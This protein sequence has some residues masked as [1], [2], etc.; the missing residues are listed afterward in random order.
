MDTES[1]PHY[2]QGIIT[3]DSADTAKEII[4]QIQQQF[5]QLFTKAQ[6]VVSPFAQG[7]PVYAPVMFRL[8]GPDEYNLRQLG[9]RYRTALAA[10]PGVTTTQATMTGGQAKLWLNI[11]EYEANNQGWN[12]RLIANRIQGQLDGVTAGSQLTG[13]EDTPVRVMLD[14]RQRQQP[15]EIIDTYFASS[16]NGGSSLLHLGSISTVEVSPA[17][18]N[19]FRRNGERTNVISAF[20]TPDALPPEVTQ[21][22]LENFQQNLPSLPPGYRLEIGGDS[23]ESEEASGNL[24]TFAPILTCMMIGAVILAFRSVS[25][26]MVIGAVAVLTIGFGLIALRVS[27]YPFGFNPLLGIAG[28]IGIAINDSIV[29]LAAIR[30]NAIAAA[31]DIAA[32]AE[33]AL[34]CSRHVIA[35]TLTT[36][37]GF[38]PLLLA[39][40]DFWP[41]LAVILAGGVAGATILATVFVP[42]CYVILVRMHIIRS[43]GSL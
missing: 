18:T 7:P 16:G 17:A 23:E 30:R 39:G 9:D 15:D 42:C 24:A 28:L 33:E 40:G 43:S 2:A 19:I 29:I 27:G 11:D 13:T 31:G 21:A 41:P 32:I 36:I 14:Q 34:G 37:G 10:V 25:I 3:A 26:A 4:P 20:V 35:T 1:S 8:V 12:K 38:L 5:D 22:A 6:I